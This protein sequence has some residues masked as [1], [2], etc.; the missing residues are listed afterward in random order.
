MT[1][2]ETPSAQEIAAL[3]SA[4]DKLTLEAKRLRR[5]VR[6]L[7]EFFTDVPPD[8]GGPM[9]EEAP[10][11]KTLAVTLGEVRR[12]ARSIRGCD[13][14]ISFIRNALRNADLSPVFRRD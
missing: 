5:D 8:S 12:A 2:R 6:Q 9:P 4:A 10:Y 3:S 13:P 11:E 14:D 1:E 7:L